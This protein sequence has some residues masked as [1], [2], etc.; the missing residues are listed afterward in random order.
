ML[1]TSASGPR[2]Y[3]KQTESDPIGAGIE[4]SSHRCTAGS[5]DSLFM[6]LSQIACERVGVQTPPYLF[7]EVES[8]LEQE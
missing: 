6:L 7:D 4:N 8:F 3:A 5:K 2:R 1:E